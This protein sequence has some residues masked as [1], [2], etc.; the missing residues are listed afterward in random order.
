VRLFPLFQISYLTPSHILVFLFPL[1]TLFLCVFDE[2]GL[3]TSNLFHKVVV[4]IDLWCCPL[5]HLIMVCLIQS[6]LLLVTLWPDLGS[7]DVA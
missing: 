7:V 2:I 5:L 1:F 6:N 3:S 4:Y